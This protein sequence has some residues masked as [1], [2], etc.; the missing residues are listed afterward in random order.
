VCPSDHCTLQLPAV[1]ANVYGVDSTVVFRPP[2]IVA[3]A[4][5]V[6]RMRGG[7]MGK[8]CA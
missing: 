4:D 8:P 2:N 7:I 3:I 6:I 1:A 5:S